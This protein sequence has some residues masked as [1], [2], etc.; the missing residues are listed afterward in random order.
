MWFYYLSPNL[1]SE[2]ILSGIQRW[3]PPNASNIVIF[4]L[5]WGASFAWGMLGGSFHWEHD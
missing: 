4:D 5:H 2:E 1:T 3:V